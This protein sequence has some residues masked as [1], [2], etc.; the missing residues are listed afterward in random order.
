VYT[1]VERAFRLD[2]ELGGE[3]A[4]LESFEGTEAISTPFHFLVRFLTEKPLQMKNLLRTEA[5]I[6]VQKDL[7]ANDTYFHGHF[8][9]VQQR[10]DSVD[11]LFA[12]EAELVPFL[13]LLELEVHCRAFHTATVEEIVSSIFADRGLEHYRFD[14]QSSLPK[15][16]YCVQ[17]RET[18]LNFVSRLLEEEGIFYF[19]QHAPGKHELVLT[20]KKAGLPVCP[21]VSG[22]QYHPL[23]GG[24][25]EADA[26][27]DLDV[28][29]RL[30]AGAAA[31]NDY[32]FETPKVSLSSS[33]DG[34]S[35]GSL[36]DYPGR[37]A[38][39]SDGDRYVRI[40]LEA[41]ET[42]SATILGTSN[43]AGFR[44][45]HLFQLR[46]HPQ[47]EL[48][49]QYLLIGIQHTGVNQSY[50]GSAD[51]HGA[52]YR[53]S[54]RA[55]PQTLQYRPPRVS[56]RALVHGT[57]T[58]VVTGP[59][60]Q[61]IFTDQY[62]R[63]KVQFFWNTDS[64]KSSCWIRVAQTWAGKNWGSVAIPRVGQEVVVDFLEGDPDR[65]LIIGCVYN[66]DQMP[67][68]TLPANKTRSGVRSH[69]SEGGATS[70][71]NELYFED[72]K[73]QE[74]LFLQAELDYQ[75]KVK[76]DRKEEIGNDDALQIGHNRS[77][78]VAVNDSMSV[79]SD[80]SADIGKNDSVTVGA[81]FSVVAG[82]EIQ[83]SA[84]GG[85]ITIG[86]DGITIQSPMTVVI[87]GAMVQIN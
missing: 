5:T 65:P 44:S 2:T 60:S 21:S 6:T 7:A 27:S 1:Q 71:C 76:H 9:S 10:A 78:S 16:D 83:F 61:E 73:G 39:K 64:E 47:N 86:A 54:F 41:E 52:S 33:L 42:R 34:S 20:D 14:L 24:I 8:W 56:P 32:N 57:Q 3:S 69:S 63:V 13:K 77:T 53:N 36:Y 79:G 17:Y 58:A 12:Y 84:P 72:L 59:A 26:V 70:N 4:L 46:S 80:R 67:P 55:I 51:S 49:K 87:Q 62:G 66:A 15:R 11:G 37:Y 38:T 31:S 35:K 23:N 74:L 75:L 30:H 45:G 22:A 18:D 25:G 40:R 50:R 82:E 85:S 48:N 81:K 43:C 68:Y 29:Y 19:F 28:Q